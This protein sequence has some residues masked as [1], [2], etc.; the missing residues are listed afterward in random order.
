MSDQHL[1]TTGAGRVRGRLDDGVH[2]FRG[3][4]YGTAVRFCA[5]EPA[6][7]W[8]GVLDATTFPDRSPQI[9][10]TAALGG[11]DDASPMSEDCLGLN[12][13]TPGIDDGSRPVM[14]WF[15]GGGFSSL[16]G[17]SAMYD[18]VRLCQRGDVVV[19]TLNHRLNL[20]GFCYLAELG[21]ERYADSGNA[22]MLDLVLALRWVR[23]N[24][25]S[26]GG[27]PGNV[28]VFGESG[29]GAKVSVLMGMPEAEGLFHKAI[30]Q[31]GVHLHAQDPAD[32][33]E[34]ARRLLHQLDLGPDDVDT[35]ASLPFEQLVDA[36]RTLLREADVAF[37]P[38]ADGIHLPRSPWRPEAPACSAAVPLIVL[39]TRTETTL[40]AGGRDPSLFELDEE[41]LPRKLRGWL[42]GADPE[43][44][45][46]GFRRLH[47]D[48]SP[49]ELFWLVTSDVY[50]R[51][52]GWVQADLKSTQGGA[53]VWMCEVHWNSPV[54]GGRWGSPHTIDIPLVFD[55]V[56]KVAS[57]AKDGPESRELAAMMSTAWAT[58][59]RTGDPNHPGIPPW[60]AY[61]A[62]APVTML[63]DLPPRVEAGWR[64]GEREVLADL[65]LR[66]TNR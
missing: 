31:S 50:S 58:F 52:P 29:G 57:F 62:E 20:F 2:V 18:G 6:P 1:A 22:G 64:A 49:S 32:A 47:P 66:D 10:A 44:V 14:V 61:R 16:S 26:F 65:P 40:L 41:R 25:A 30:V 11:D 17:S 42:G 12:V 63:F 8:A 4:P 60:P 36:H 15:H 37:S 9:G 53:P 28:T 51:M 27:D 56:A 35:L 48:A 13:W 34:N 45:I 5:P 3:I 23:D 59:A 39:S 19:V 43:P 33:T 38:V 54:Q 46:E 55:N 7:P 21:G 24:I